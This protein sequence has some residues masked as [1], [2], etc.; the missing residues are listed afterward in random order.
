MAPNTSPAES[1]SPARD[2]HD[3]SRDIPTPRLTALATCAVNTQLLESRRQSIDPS[4]SLGRSLELASTA[5]TL[6]TVTDERTRSD[7]HKD[8]NEKDRETK[9]DADEGEGEERICNRLESIQVTIGNLMQ[10]SLELMEDKDARD[11]RFVGKPVSRYEAEIDLEAVRL[12]FTQ[13][14]DP[15][16]D[17]ETKERLRSPAQ[18]FVKQHWEEIGVWNT[19]WVQKTAKQNSWKWRWQKKQSSSYLSITEEAIK[20]CGGMIPGQYGQET[21][22]M[23]QNQQPASTWT[24]AEGDAFI[25]SRPWFAFEIECMVEFARR[26]SLSEQERQSLSTR[27]A[28]YIRRQW[29]QAG[30]WNTN[31]DLLSDVRDEPIVGWRW[32][33]E[34]I[35]EP[36]RA[37]LS[38][39]NSEGSLNLRLAKSRSPR[40]AIKV[41]EAG[42]REEQQCR[43]SFAPAENRKRK[44]DPEE[45]SRPEPRDDRGQSKAGRK[46]A[47]KGSRGGRKGTDNNTP[48]D[49]G[50][51]SSKA[52][53]ESR[54]DGDKDKENAKLLP[55]KRSAPA[56]PAPPRRSARIAARH[57]QRVVAAAAQAAAPSLA[58]PAPASRPAPA[59]PQANTGRRRRRL[60][61][62]PAGNVVAVPRA[63][64]GRRRGGR[65]AETSAEDAVVTNTHQAPP[66]AK[67][68]RR[69]G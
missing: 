64:G 58:P 5:D 56:P 30:I 10:F 55:R 43:D 63:A 23:P 37:D 27:A 22:R 16:L 21:K 29:L 42:E 46:E 68:R 26:Q 13:E 3:L 18:S 9:E 51:G 33:D 31:W 61:E 32:C 48:Y 19:A 8:A 66:A 49:N 60:P 59:R 67:R 54:P 25:R 6:S 34:E 14:S 52:A 69:R 24:E 39:F 36:D 47:K 38:E 17:R 15:L 2:T 65:A 11:C 57:A 44:R 35:A 50:E 28:G 4:Q 40:K 20:K 45:E 7:L 12:A 1:M 41:E 53:E 62:Q